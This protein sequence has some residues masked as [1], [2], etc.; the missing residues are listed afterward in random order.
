MFT[1]K[2]L[3]AMSTGERD[4]EVT[5]THFAIHK[6]IILYFYKHRERLKYAV[7]MFLYPVEK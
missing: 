6:A 5:A 1:S 7:G 2:T 3:L 4:F